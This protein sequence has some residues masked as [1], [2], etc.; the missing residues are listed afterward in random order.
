MADEY[1]LKDY[2][3]GAEATTL[4]SGFTI[5]STT[6]TVA[7][8][9]T[10]PTGTGG[11]FVIVVD[12]GLASE[13]K[14]LIDTTSGVNGVTF[15]IQQAGYDGTTASNHGVGATVEHCIDAYTI[16][17]ANRYVNLQTTKGDLVAHT[18]TT[19]ARHAAGANNTV[20][21]ADSGQ[22]NG[23]RWGTLAAASLAS[24]SVTTAKIVD[25]NVTT[26]KL[27]DSAVTSAKIA[28]GTIVNADINA[29]AAIELSKLATG[30]LP[31]A[32]TVASAN[33]VNDTIVDADINS[34]AAI[35]P[36]KIA[37]VF[38]TGD[39]SNNRV[40]ISTATPTSLDGADGDVW[41]KY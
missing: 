37:G 28:D 25:L 30:A 18:G 33:I 26:G 5:G 14:F 17:Q 13:E 36:S 12:R 15:N 11:P 8:G 40:Y 3:G 29:S 41:L 32:I 16:E 39:S 23:L 7:D 31:T 20:L 22:S 35:T 21:V 2:A 9:S 19:T 1:I 27:A 34:S 4:A 38:V 24:D 10:Y 6:L